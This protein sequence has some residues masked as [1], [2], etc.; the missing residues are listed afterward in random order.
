M[1]PALQVPG[2]GR[3]RVL[4][5]GWPSFLHGEA[6][7]GDVLAM[8]AA[9][10]ALS[11]AG[12]ECDL[13]WSPVFRPGGR[14]LED[15]APDDYTH[16]VF[17]CGPVHGWQIERLH[18][19][20]RG[21]HR[22]AVGVSVIDPADPAV[23][24]FHQVLPRDAPGTAGRLDLAAAV[25]VPAVPVAAVILAGAQPEYAAR[26]RH[27]LLTDELGGWLADLDCARVVV[28][29]RLAHRDWRNPATAAQVEAI[30]GR[31]DVV[32][33]TRLH[34]LVLALKQGVPVLAV[35]PVAG[36]AKVAAQ[37]GAWGWPVLLPRS[38]HPLLD[39]G[40]L[41]RLWSWCRSAEGRARAGSALGARDTPPL[42]TDLLSVLA[43]AAATGMHG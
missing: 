17:T 14:T 4:I 26:G 2:P 30:I 36:G 10:T 27:S 38:G 15:C 8:E 1:I 6:T 33:T 24:G 20:Y 40:E 21:C 18:D 37:A 7:A 43:G 32:V 28:D 11:D 5:A 12:F 25:P 31:A 41:D 29:T 34:G 13:A 23:T 9:R 16:L 19:R 42:T 35:D 22:V 39:Q 3:G